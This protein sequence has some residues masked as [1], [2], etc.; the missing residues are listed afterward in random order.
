MVSR[1]VTYLIVL[2]TIFQ[3]GVTKLY[4]QAQKGVSSPVEKY[5]YVVVLEND[6]T[7]VLTDSVFY[8]ISRKVIFPVN[9]YTIP[10]SSD[11]RREIVEELMPYMNDRYHVL[12]RVVVRGA[13]S[14]EGPLRW[15]RFLAE[16]RAK[17]LTELIGE[18]SR[19]G[20]K[21]QPKTELMAEDYIYLLLLL[22]EK[23][24]KDYAIVA[25]IVNRWVDTDQAK[26]KKELRRYN[27]GRLWR[28]LLREYFPGLRA[29]RVVLVFRKLPGYEI[30][31][32]KPVKPGVIEFTGKVTWPDEPLAPLTIERVRS[33][34]RE[35]LSVKT[36]LLFDLAYMPGYGR[37][38]PIPNVAVEYYPL[39]GH[40]T[41]GA[42]VDFPWWQH[43]NT[44]KYFQV[45]N[46]QLEAR[47]Y[48]RSGS[49]GEHGYGNGPAFRGWYLQG[50][51]H[52][53][54]YDICFDTD[55]G[56]EG[57]GLG[58]G[59]GVGYVM[60][61]G[62]NGRWRLEAGAQFG[63]FWTKYDPYQWQCP[64]DGAGG[65][66]KYYYKWTGKAEDF[67]ERQY[68]FNWIGPTRIGITLTYDLIYRKRST[69]SVSFNRW[70]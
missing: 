9:K 49:V 20:I 14:P 28:R 47:Y 6:S 59:L 17:A 32:P 43:Y 31:D 53:G 35:L 4:A 68:R 67:K 39:H 45:R 2:A 22:Q 18:N 57:E 1:I 34:R 30:I 15:N 37:F 64:V 5:A 51:A 58:A 62:K 60:P 10:Q 50:Y 12:D 27:G 52:A 25:D 16:H 55:R 21:E 36:N 54:L 3:T 13:A 24:D 41:F 26:L 19:I 56:W 29:A 46:Y 48:L 40:F 61:L 8:R 44:Q 42:S 69:K 66:D 23:G 7:F 63:Y 11:F 33:P 38:C 70:E 65:G